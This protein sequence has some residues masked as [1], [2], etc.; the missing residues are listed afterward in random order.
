MA[1][2]DDIA[3]RYALVPLVRTQRR[4]SVRP[5]YIPHADIIHRNG[6]RYRNWLRHYDEELFDLYDIFQRVAG[7][8]VEIDWL[9]PKVQIS[10]LRGI[11]DYST[12][13]IPK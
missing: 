4:I 8:D 6:S 11:F 10:F 3:F 5:G 1:R 9:S 13:H 7:R 2:S 12:G